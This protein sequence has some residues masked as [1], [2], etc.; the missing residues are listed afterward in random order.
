MYIYT[1]NLGLGIAVSVREKEQSRFG[2][3]IDGA[4][5]E[6]QGNMSEQGGAERRYKGRNE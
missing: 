5:E 2:E 1:P 3:S 6:Q 4:A